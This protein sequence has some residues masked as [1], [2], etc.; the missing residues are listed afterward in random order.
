[1]IYVII[2][3]S[4]YNNSNIFYLHNFVA[5]DEKQQ[6][7]RREIESRPIFS[8]ESTSSSPSTSDATESKRSVQ[9]ARKKLGLIPAAQS[10]FSHMKSGPQNITPFSPSSLGIVRKKS[11]NS[12]KKKEECSPTDDPMSPVSC[13]SSPSASAYSSSASSLSSLSLPTSP[14]SQDISTSLEGKQLVGDHSGQINANRTAEVC[15]TSPERAEAK[16]IMTESEQ[17]LM[18]KNALNS[19]MSNYESSNESGSDSS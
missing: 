16:N 10:P 13:V 11:K 2:F 7:I 19:L 15:V 12:D 14:S 9:L 18:K 6:Q 8:T 4:F 1:M 17:I 3:F 5:F